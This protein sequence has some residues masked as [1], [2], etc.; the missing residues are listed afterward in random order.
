M[1]PVC[2]P[3]LIQHGLYFNKQINHWAWVGGWVGGS[4]VGNVRCQIWGLGVRRASKKLEPNNNNNNNNIM[5]L[6]K[7]Q[8][9]FTKML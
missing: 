2:R 3:P 4:N 8:V 9:R 7:D 5:Y 1:P 6:L